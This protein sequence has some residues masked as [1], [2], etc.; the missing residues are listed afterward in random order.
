MK[1]KISKFKK[2][3]LLLL[4]NSI[5]T[6]NAFAQMQT[7]Y[8]MEPNPEPMPPLM[9]GSPQL[10]PDPQENLLGFLF[11]MVRMFAIPIL[12]FIVLIVGIVLLIRKIRTKSKK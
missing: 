3:I 5:F 4:V 2:L 7:F 11:A 10:F 12:V 1:S 9:Y 6:P 8:G